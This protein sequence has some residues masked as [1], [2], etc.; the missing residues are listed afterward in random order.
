MGSVDVGDGL[1]GFD[2]PDGLMNGQGLAHFGKLH[3]DDVA[4]LFLGEIRDPDHGFFAFD[5][6]PLMFLRVMK[7][8]RIHPRLLGYLIP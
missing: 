8:V 3:V 4:Q 5:P 6:D 1:D 2:D 7:S